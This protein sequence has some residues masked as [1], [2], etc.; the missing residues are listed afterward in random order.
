M[1]H[2]P[3]DFDE[4]SEANL[5]AGTNLCL[6]KVYREIERWHFSM[7][8]FPP[9]HDAIIEGTLLML[10]ETT[11][12]VAVPVQAMKNGKI[13]AG[14]LSDK[15][16]EYQFI[17][18]KPGTYQVR[19][20]V[21]GGYIYYGR[22]KGIVV[23]THRGASLQVE[24]GKTLKN[25]DFLIPPFKKGS[26][27]T[28]NY[29]LN[30][31]AGNYIAAI[32]QDPD[33]VLWFGADGGVSRYDGKAFVSFTEKDGLAGNRV[34]AIHCTPDGVIWIGTN[35][36][37]SRYDGKEGPRFVNFTTK[38]GLGH[39]GVRAIHRDPDGAV[40]FGTRGGGVSRY[41]GKEGP[42]FVN[43]TEKDGL[44]DNVVYAIHRDPDGAMWFGTRGGLSRY[45]GSEFVNFT[46]K[47]GLPNNGIVAIHRDPDGAMWFGTGGGV[48]RYGGKGG[49]RFVNFI[50]KDGL[51][52]DVV[53][54]IHHD[55]DGALWFGTNEGVTQYRPRATPPSV[56]IV[57]VKTDQL[58]TDLSAIPP[59]PTGTRLTIEYNAIDFKTI[60]EKRQYRYRIYESRNT[61]HAIRNTQYATRNTQ[62]SSPTKAT[63]F[64]WTPKK[65][66]TYTFSVQAID[67]DLNYSEPASLTLKVV[68]PWYLNGWVAIPS[69]GTILV[70]LIASIFF[71]L[72][73]YTQRRETQ[74]V[75]AQ[76]LE[77]EREAHEQE[78]RARREIEAKAQELEVAKDAAEAANRAKST[79]LANMSHEIRTPMNAILGYAQ[80]L[81]RTPDLPP[82]QRDAVNTIER[83]GDHLLELINDVLDL[84][85]IEA[86]RMELQETDF[87][88][89][90]LIYTLSTMFQMRCQQ[91]G[92]DW[93]VE[94]DVERGGVGARERG[95]EETDD[96]PP[97]LH[98]ST[99]ARLL[100]HGDEGKLRQ[101]LIN[102]LGNAVKFTDEGGETQT[103]E[104]TP[105]FPIR[106]SGGRGRGHIALRSSTLV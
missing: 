18:L 102:L 87:D 3:R 33:G 86:G 35:G 54:V 2:N 10:D 11:P 89:N 19:C 28:Y 38:D 103:E 83:S 50:E 13:I 101:I 90:T 100:V 21:L 12:H 78:A 84:S 72:R 65:P 9:D 37:V 20:H 63:I 4:T 76:M 97:R 48:S 57:S 23:E 47:D 68:P 53:T 70:L 25:I 32:D 29:L 73:Y 96:M 7:R 8:V 14:T 71:G 30:G 74:R 66:G 79:F 105:L 91:Q 1:Y 81:Q 49:P 15:K 5:K 36:G 27:E 52:D 43:F 92:L 40:W 67:R 64:D 69:G 26:W 99:P 77:Q 60:P 39:N 17:N 62:Y 88:L 34:R 93:R 80:I 56:R 41:D 58:Y 51:A 59:I 95:S 44:A 61:Q 46:T 22:K 45:D 82:D 104:T 85:K 16:G 31:L 24:R 6:V 75:Q 55:P 98:T 94:W 106:G 42:R